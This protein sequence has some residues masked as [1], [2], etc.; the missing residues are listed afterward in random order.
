[1]PIVVGSPLVVWVGYRPE[2]FS[3]IKGNPRSFSKTKG[4]VRTFCSDCGTSIGYLDEG[5]SSE[6]YAD[7]EARAKRRS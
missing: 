3:V 6:L 1:M 7:K 2:Q 5:I 4:V